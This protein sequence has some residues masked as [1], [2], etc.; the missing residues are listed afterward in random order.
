MSVNSEYV[1]TN[2]STN[3]LQTRQ[4]PLLP[5]L[6]KTRKSNYDNKGVR[7]DCCH[8]IDDTIWSTLS[9]QW[10]KVVHARTYPRALVRCLE[11]LSGARWGGSCVVGD[12][13]YTTHHIQTKNSNLCASVSKAPLTCG[14]HALAPL[15]PRH[16]AK[17]GQKPGKSRA[18]AGQKPGKSRKA[19]Q[20]PHV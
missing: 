13:D 6:Q 15:R 10:Q 19:A 1:S 14:C 8:A 5:S 12:K 16:N 9:T 20:K 3:T 7:F 2:Q 11:C 4:N 17:A 18:K